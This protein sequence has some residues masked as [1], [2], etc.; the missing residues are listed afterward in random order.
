MEHLKDC[1]NAL[2]KTADTLIVHSSKLRKGSGS[3]AA[4]RILY[5]CLPLLRGSADFLSEEERKQLQQMEDALWE[6]LLALRKR[7]TPLSPLLHRLHRQSRKMIRSLPKV[8][9]VWDSPTVLVGTL[10]I[11]EQLDICL[12]Y[13]FYHVPACQIPDHWLPFSYV[14]IYQSRTLFPDDCGIFFYGKV[15]SCSAIRRCKIYEIPKAS[16]DLYYR[17]DVECWEPLELPVS[18][19][20][21]PITHLLTNL[22]LL[23]H[24]M[25]TPEL[26]LKTP[27]HYLLYQAIGRALELGNGTVFRYMGGSVH[28]KNRL[29]QVRR[30]GRVIASFLTEDF[31]R[32]PADIFSQIMNIL[33]RKP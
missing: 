10:R 8:P 23:Q 24:S 25:E 16:D 15:K 22:F 32:T 29:I 2:L 21:L 14:A 6:R 31:I 18:V 1:C 27:R 28:M 19:R 7:R 13:G 20:E 33:E 5:P 9:D 12:E 30:R 17:L 26:T 3:S 4:E 11:P